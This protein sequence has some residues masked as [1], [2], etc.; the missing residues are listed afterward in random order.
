M[1]PCLYTPYNAFTTSV[2]ILH[3]LTELT[4]S[5]GRVTSGGKSRN[6]QNKNIMSGWQ[7]NATRSPPSHS[8]PTYRGS[9]YSLA[10]RTG[11]RKACQISFPVYIGVIQSLTTIIFYAFSLLQYKFSCCERMGTARVDVLCEWQ[12]QDQEVSLASYSEAF[13]LPTTY[14]SQCF[15]RSIRRFQG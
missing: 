11:V 10:P 12:D 7:G 9:S 14:F 15:R 8:S 3:T 5:S 13:R 2:Y 4:E 6:T 1:L